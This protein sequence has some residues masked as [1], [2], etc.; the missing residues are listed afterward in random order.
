MAAARR[1]LRVI[2]WLQPMFAG[3]PACVKS[4]TTGLLLRQWL[5]CSRYK[6][7]VEG[8]PKHM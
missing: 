7:T 3:N 4:Q 2:W 1:Q 5:K 8:I 6:S